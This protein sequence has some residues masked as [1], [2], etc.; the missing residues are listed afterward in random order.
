M[1]LNDLDLNKLH[2]FRVVAESLSMRESAER[3]FRTPSAVSQSIS[4]LEV[5]LQTLL[6][7]RVGIRLRL[8]EAG[9]ALL[10]Q[11]KRNEESL[12]SVIEQLQGRAEGIRGRIALGL[13]PGYPAASLSGALTDLLLEHPDLQLR[14]RFQP[15]EALARLLLKGDL[16][17]ALSFH[18]L[19]RWSARIRS[20][21][22][23]GEDLILV[24]PG[25]YRSL[26]DQVPGKFPVVDYYQKPL[27]IEGWIRH[28][29]L[30]A[31]HPQIR[32][33]GSSLEHVLAMVK[34]GVGCAVVPKHIVQND[35]SYGGLLE[36]RLDKK[37]PWRA[38]I[39]VNTVTSIQP[40]AAQRLLREALNQV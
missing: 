25:L 28:H 32:V 5:S 30:K 23:R 34:R 36:H 12:L 10:T 27:L 2:V 24:L 7:N 1:K 11:V 16:D 14:L 26:A 9:R 6:F 31:A 19:R 38:Q 22:L 20:E 4:S 40:T 29:A 39:W 33:F 13:P 21:A 18:P 35:L 8:T 15:H 3:L 37:N 17:L